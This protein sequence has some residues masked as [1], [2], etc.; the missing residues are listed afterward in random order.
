M[1]RSILL[2]GGSRQQVVAIKKAKELGYRTVV[3]DYLPDNP[4]QFEADV[5]YQESTTDRDA[6]LNIAIKENVSGVLAYSSDPAASTAGYV[7]ERMG[8]PTNPLR[9]IEIMSVKH[10]FRSFMQDSALPCPRAVSIRMEED[11]EEIRSRVSDL[12]FPIVVKPTDSSGSKG[13][14]FI[15]DIEQLGDALANAKKYSRN[16][17]LIA[18]ECIRKTYPE[19]IGGDIF[20]VDGRIQFYGLMTCSRDVKLGGLVPVG[21]K[22]PPSISQS[23]FD[24]ICAVLQ[25]LVTKL[26]LRFGELNV[27]VIIGEGGIPYVIELG[28]RAGGNMIPIQLSDASGIDLVSANVLAAMGDDNLDLRWS[29]YGSDVPLATYVVHSRRSGVLESVAIP[30]DVERH[31]YRAIWYK[32]PGDAV[33]RFDGADKALGILFLK[34][35]N[36][37]QMRE[38]CSTLCDRVQVVLRGDLDEE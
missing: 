19:V 30:S 32:K 17:V 4:G 27:E 10:L 33:C 8:L 20:V 2:L 37:D 18:E 31:V 36:N 6:I 34:F 29:S 15:D 24:S 5:F 3:C 9:S 28:S 16:S 38:I 25:K 1:K 21:K 35:E 23:E 11:F 22:M 7:A 13:V 12:H 14:R 26:N